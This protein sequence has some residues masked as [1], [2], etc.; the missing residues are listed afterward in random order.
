MF[1]GSSLRPDSGHCPYKK[2]LKA[3][4]GLRLPPGP[5]RGYKPDHRETFNL[6][7]VGA[8]LDL[9]EYAGVH[10]DEAIRRS[11]AATH[12]RP[13]ADPGLAA[14]TRFAVGQYLEG[15]PPGLLP[16]DC[17]WIVVTALGQT[18][19]RGARRY[20]QCVWGRPYVST[21]GRV[22]ELCVPVARSATQAR[23]TATDTIDPTERADLAA[24]AH[25]LSRGTPHRLPDRF[26]WSDD[27]APAT[28]VD[29]AAWGPPEEVRI[30]EVSCVDGER[31]E[32]LRHNPDEV[33][34]RYASYGAPELTAA[35]SGNAFVPG[36]D[37]EDCKY[38]PSCPALGRLG[39]VLDI[40]D[41]TRP[42]R[43]WSV[44][45]GRSYAGRP[46]RD[47]G[48]PARERLRRLRLPDPEARSLT[49][50]VIRGHAVHAWIQQRHETY[51]GRACRPEDAPDGRS[52]WSAGRWTV[53]QEQ[54]ELGA[55]MV[56]AHARHCPYSLSSVH[57]VIHERTIVL[58]DTSA[59]VLVLAKTDMLYR[60][61]SSWVYRETKTDARRNPAQ[62][63]D[64]F[65]ERP[66]LALAVLL[67]TSPLLGDN[68]SAAR[69]ELEVLGPTGAQLTIIDP[70]DPENRAAARRAVHELAA[71]WHRDTVAPARPGS[72]C[73]DCEM[74]VWCRPS[75]PT[76]PASYSVASPGTGV[77]KG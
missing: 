68:V 32:L 25:V 37:C 67:S 2:S 71:D 54:A 60:D 1:A 16:V 22:R 34:Q 58:H 41:R 23:R 55:R 38:A 35:V 39:G 63:T 64:I 53:P 61:G 11:L 31:V 13:E 14:W 57:E 72:H 75:L 4:T 65:R 40:D 6:G 9:V 3:R 62:T 5:L 76:G 27:A 56:A 20:E 12:E 21:D 18:D 48:C 77:V 49:P 33:A 7:P 47:E 15:R 73:R 17:T 26:H 36:F 52:A 30:T 59:D 24:A 19:A 51:P 46:G 74:A 45:N 29:E 70:F 42:R 69:V 8:A 66:Q 50:H 10:P 43:V 28:N 44:T